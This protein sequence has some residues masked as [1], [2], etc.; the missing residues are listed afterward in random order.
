MASFYRIAGWRFDPAEPVLRDG[1]REVPLEDR[2][3]RALAML[4]EHRGTVVSKDALLAR[5]WEG[6][7]VSS[8]SVSIVIGSLRR[9]LEDDLQTP[10]HIVTVAR[11]GYRLTEETAVAGP[12]HATG[13]RRK[14]WLSIPASSAAMAGAAVIWLPVKEPVAI[15]VDAPQN[16]TG[17]AALNGL[18]VSLAPVVVAA[19]AGL[20]GVEVM[21]TGANA[22]R[23][24]RVRLRSRIILWDGAPELSM[25]ATDMRTRTVIWTGF[26]AGPAAAL[27]RHVRARIGTLQQRLPR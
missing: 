24:R 6:R 27:A 18:A 20:N 10:V 4:C 12:R 22:S 15:V 17:S 13:C 23:A 2:A 14:L 16:A 11:R 3:A 25:V 9:A 7:T 1:V 8:N 26:A 5:V 21:D 19:V